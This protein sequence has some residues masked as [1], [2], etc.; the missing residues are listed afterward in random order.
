MSKFTI[1]TPD[2]LLTADPEHV[3][4]QAKQAAVE[5]AIAHAEALNPL[6]E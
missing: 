6:E 4:A 1:H 3:F 5:L 2:T